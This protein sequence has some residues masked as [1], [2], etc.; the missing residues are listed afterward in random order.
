[1]GFLLDL[2]LGS[3]SNSDP[4][5][6]ERSE[7]IYAYGGDDWKY[8]CDSKGHRTGE[9]KWNPREDRWEKLG[10]NGDTVEYIERFGREYIHRDSC[11]YFTGKD[12]IE[13][14]R[15]VSHYD[16]NGKKIGYITK[17]NFNNLTR[18]TY[19]EEKKDIFGRKKKK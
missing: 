16:R 12:V 18:H 19:I 11:G 17:D 10:F 5:P 1:M 2:L 7:R 8:I 15:T 14:S 9:F 13:D 3:R 4:A 6:E